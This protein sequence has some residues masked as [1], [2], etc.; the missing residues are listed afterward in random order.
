MKA[1]IFMEKIVVFLIFFTRVLFKKELFIF[2]ALAIDIFFECEKKFIS[3]PQNE[4][5]IV[6]SN[7]LNGANIEY[8]RKAKSCP[9]TYIK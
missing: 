1:I 4:T 3:S 6:P 8:N 7:Y 5:H 2:N 9:H